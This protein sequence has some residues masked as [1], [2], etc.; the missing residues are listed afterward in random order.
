MVQREVAPAESA[1]VVEEEAQEETAPEETTTQ[2]VTEADQP[3]EEAPTRSVRPGRKPTPPPAPAPTQVAEEPDAR[4]TLPGLAETIAGAVSEANSESAVEDNANP[5]G[6]T[7]EPV[8]RAEKGAFILAIQR[9]W[10]VGALSTDALRV[11]VVVGFT[12]TPDAR[13]EIGSIR[14]VRA[15]GGSGGAVDR[16]YE[17]ARRAIIRCGA[18]GFGLPAEKYNQWRGVEVRFNATTKEIR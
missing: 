7:G 16:A 8:T 1:D 6:G 10:N 11:T 14:L 9:C 13:P 18:A 17:S 2:V 4:P 15:E 3:S 12:M 5:G